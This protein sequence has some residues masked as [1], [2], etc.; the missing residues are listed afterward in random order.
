MTL[1]KFVF[2]SIHIKT[3]KEFEQFGSQKMWRENIL[4]RESSKGIQ[5]KRWY[6]KYEIL[7]NIEKTQ[8][9]FTAVTT[10]TRPQRVF[11]SVQT[12]GLVDANN[13]PLQWFLRVGQEKILSPFLEPSDENV[14]V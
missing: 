12:C 9:S 14:G 11:S 3:T 5:V 1:T 2:H 6:D 10:N 8:L 7:N 4:A 13:Q